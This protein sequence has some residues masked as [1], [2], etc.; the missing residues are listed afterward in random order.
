THRLARWSLG[1]VA[2]QRTKG[3]SWYWEAAGQDLLHVGFDHSELLLTTKDDPA[4]YQFP[5]NAGQ[6]PLELDGWHVI[7]DGL[8][9]DYRLRFP[10]STTAAEKAAD[11][12]SAVEAAADR[13]A[14][15]TIP[16]RVTQVVK[17]LQ[18]SSLADRNGFRRELIVTGV[19]A[20]RQL[21]W[22]LVDPKRAAKAELRAAGRELHWPDEGLTIE[23][24]DESLRLTADG[25]CLIPTTGRATLAYRT[26]LQNDQYPGLPTAPVAPDGPTAPAKLVAPPAS[27]VPP[28]SAT[29]HKPP[30]VAGETPELQE[31]VPGFQA[32]RLPLPETIM[33]T[34]LAWRPDRA[35]VIASLR[36]RVWQAS[37]TDGDQLEDELT[38]ISDELAAP[39]GL[40]TGP[41][42]VDVTTKY[43][44]LRLWDRNR[45]AGENRG[46][47]EVL[48]AGW[49]HTDDYHDWTV[50][51]PRDEQGNYF[52]ALA[53]QQDQR[54]A[55]AARWRG[56]VMKLAPR[57]PTSA[58][59]RR[60]ALEV[61][62]RGHRFPMGMVLRRDGSLLV[63]DNQGNYNPFN[64]LNH[65]IPGRH[66]GFINAWEQR[67]GRKP[68]GMTESAAIEIP[69]PWTRSVNGLALLDHPHSAPTA[70]GPWTG[71][72]IGCEYDTRRLVRLSLQ[73]MGDSF[74]GAV[75]PFSREPVTGTAPEH[76]FLGP[77][78]A[79]VSPTGELYVGGIR[80]SGWGGGNNIGEVV[81]LR[82]DER[83]G[84]AG[85]A[86]RRATHTGFL[87]T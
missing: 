31:V 13:A 86:E 23:V 24:Q 55:A 41:D 8:Q 44:V 25:T 49:G 51:L 64:E 18:S 20:N 47:T 33:P 69:H 58:D 59:P 28:A 81:K 56:T 19:P 3:K 39:Y 30:S 72:L 87:L 22:K 52:I 34:A 10:T 61:V 60:Y 54:S 85:W 29:R 40:A 79:E 46:R 14:V 35:L 7:P 76:G 11:A 21:V 36:G 71:H 53:C 65:V 43:A 75:Y 82:Y 4:R 78:C 70:F 77:L 5:L 62:S 63:T 17:A 83:T 42:Y 66:Y 2:R 84:P 48:A 80:D 38:A 45:A 73:N 74:Q 15:A 50:G 1:D 67:A 6:F 16:L 57:S 9:W 26:T 12:T 68:D 37:D 32:T 27:T